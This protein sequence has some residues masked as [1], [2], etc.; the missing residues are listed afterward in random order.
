MRI[1][2]KLYSYKESQF[3][4]FPVFVE[5]LNHGPVHPVD[6]FEELKGHC[7]AVSDFVEVLD[8]LFALRVIS[9]DKQ[10]GEINLVN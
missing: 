4:H 5:A 1:P 2:S 9:V 6:L 7:P 10:S 8:A 3:P